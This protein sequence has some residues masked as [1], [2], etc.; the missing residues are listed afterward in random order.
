MPGAITMSSTTVT[1]PAR[2]TAADYRAELYRIFEE[3]DRVEER[4]RARDVEVE[5]LKTETRKILRD[6]GAKL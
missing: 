6:L 1:R 2:K 4:M 5:R 3:F